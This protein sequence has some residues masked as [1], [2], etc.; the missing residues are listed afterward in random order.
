[1]ALLA[2]LDHPDASLRVP[3]SAVAFGQ[4]VAH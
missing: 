4:G 1:M 3:S 2:E